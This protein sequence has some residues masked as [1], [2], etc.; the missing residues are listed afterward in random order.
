[1]ATFL[2][3]LLTADPSGFVLRNR[4]TGAVMADVLL[5]AFDS[6]KRRTG[7]LKHTGLAPGEAMIIAPTNAIHTFFMKFA[8]DVAFVARDGR[9]LK[10]SQ[11]VPAWRVRAAWRAFS[12]IE[13]AAGSFRTSHTSVGDIVGLESRVLS[14]RGEG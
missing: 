9:I 3:P 12:V 10:V 1:M 8:I 4:R 6:E 11:G 5:P 2:S 13:M 7:L 14:S